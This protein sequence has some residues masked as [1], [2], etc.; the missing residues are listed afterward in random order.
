VVKKEIKECIE[1]SF[2]SFLNQKTSKYAVNPTEFFKE[3]QYS[4]SRHKDTMIEL[5]RGKLT[6]MSSSLFEIFG[7]RGLVKKAYK[8]L[9]ND[10]VDFE[11]IQT[12][13]T[14]VTKS[15]LAGL[16][17]VLVPQDTTHISLAGHAK[18]EGLGKHC[19]KTLGLLAHSA[20][21][22]TTNGEAIGLLHQEVW[23]R[24]KEEGTFFSLDSDGNPKDESTPKRQP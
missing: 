3:L 22:F 23:T 17:R 12:Q 9:R 21:A 1:S 6:N 15:K 16:D 10:R 14:S 8:L 13:A 7:G 4:D 24:I 11:G 5:V 19:E 20:A 2:G 18:T